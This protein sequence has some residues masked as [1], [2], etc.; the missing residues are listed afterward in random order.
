M[1][2][3]E[4]SDDRGSEFAWRKFYIYKE[5]DKPPSGKSIGDTV[6]VYYEGIEEKTLTASRPSP[7]KWDSSIPE[8]ISGSRQY[9]DQPFLRLAMA[10]LLLGEAQYKLGEL[11][12]AATTFNVLRDRA[13]AS[14]ITGADLSID[15]ILDERA[16]ELYG[17]ERRRYTLLRN[18]KWLERTR[19]Y[20]QV[21][22]ANIEDF[23]VLYPI[24]QEVIDANNQLE[25]KQNPGY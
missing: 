21:A 8:D 22:S 17:E 12:N 6:F 5:G 11:D 9:D 16:R 19:K 24:P 7:R 3:Y 10:Y 1:E 23:H 13:N 4:D 2:L 20:N 14:R 25:M 18:G 15:W